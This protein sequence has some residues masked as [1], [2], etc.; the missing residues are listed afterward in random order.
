MCRRSMRRVPSMTSACGSRRFFLVR[1][2]SARS[3]AR[4]LGRRA[5]HGACRSDDRQFHRRRRSRDAVGFWLGVGTVRAR[6]MRSASANVHRQRQCRRTAAAAR[7]RCLACWPQPRSRRAAFR[8]PVPDLQILRSAKD[9]QRIVRRNSG[10]SLVDLGDGVL[11]RRISFE[12]ECDRR[13]HHCRCYRPASRKPPPISQALVI[14]NDAPNFSAGANLMLLLIEA[15][16]GNWDEIDLM[17]RT[18]QAATWRCDMPTCQS[19]RARP[20]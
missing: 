19:C 4:R 12:D 14:G 16:E 13:R 5:L 3:S 18:F 7:W 8:P 1:T 10:A 2:R 11:A 15:Q 17:V 6:W 20:V 9:R